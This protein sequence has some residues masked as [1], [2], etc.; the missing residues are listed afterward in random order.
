MKYKFYLFKVFLYDLSIQVQL[1]LNIPYRFS[2][3]QTCSKH[4]KVIIFVLASLQHAYTG[5]SGSSVTA[6]VTDSP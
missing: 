6:A 4:V 3:S 1:S 2:R 5:I